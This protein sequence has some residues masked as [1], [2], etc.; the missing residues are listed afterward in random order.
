MCDSKWGI[1]FARPVTYASP[2]I[3]FKLLILTNSHDTTSYVNLFIITRSYFFIRHILLLRNSYTHTHTP[4]ARATYISLQASLHSPGVSYMVSRDES[5]LWA[6]PIHVHCLAAL[7][8]DDTGL[9][10]LFPNLENTSQ[11]YVI[12]AFLPY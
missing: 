9:F 3:P 5:V 2:Q 11:I 6:S 1:K 10:L 8:S 12:H 4:T 7:S